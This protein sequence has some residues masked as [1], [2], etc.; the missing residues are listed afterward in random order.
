MAQSPPAPAPSYR[1]L[2]WD[3]FEEKL[4]K[5]QRPVVGGNPRLE[6]TPTAA[7][8]SETKLSLS[9]GDGPP[10][11]DVGYY[12]TDADLIYRLKVAAASDTGINGVKVVV[13]ACEPS[14]SFQFGTPFRVMHEGPV[15]NLDAGEEKFPELFDVWVKQR[16]DVLVQPAHGFPVQKR[17]ASAGVYAV[18]VKATGERTAPCVKNLRV[19]IQNDP[20]NPV[21]IEAL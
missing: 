10:F 21:T 6:P 1:K 11:R 7:H 15:F 3:D 14:G 8:P 2:G 18:T 19:T 20:V 13:S 9:Y 16:D 5:I 4:A 17:E 12:P